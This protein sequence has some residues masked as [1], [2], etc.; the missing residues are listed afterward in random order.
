MQRM[1]TIRIV[2]GKYLAVLDHEA[3]KEDP[4]VG[5]PLSHQGVSSALHYLLHHLLLYLGSHCRGGGVGPHAP[6]IGP[7]IALAHCLVVLRHRGVGVEGLTGLP[8][9]ITLT[10]ATMC[11]KL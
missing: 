1:A 11:G 10:Q 3:G 7:S 9:P 5:A 2:T 4:P 8:N 6:R